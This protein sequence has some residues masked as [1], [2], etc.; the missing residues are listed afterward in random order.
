[1]NEWKNEQINYLINSLPTKIKRGNV[2]IISEYALVHC[3]V[4]LTDLI[5]AYFNV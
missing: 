2:L 3:N 4:Y 1:M 5:R